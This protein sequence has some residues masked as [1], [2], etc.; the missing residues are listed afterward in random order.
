MKG[1]RSNKQHGHISLEKCQNLHT[2]V[3]FVINVTALLCLSNGVFSLPIRFFK[4]ATMILYQ[5]N[6]REPYGIGK[7][8]ATRVFALLFALPH[9]HTLSPSKV[10]F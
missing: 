5:H 6:N 10:F 8:V 1:F 3:H 2:D 4:G 9:P 7:V